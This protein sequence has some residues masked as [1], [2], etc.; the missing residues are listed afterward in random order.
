MHSVM[1]R[2]NQMSSSVLVMGALLLVAVAMS[3]QWL[4]REP[5]LR[6]AFRR[7]QV[8]ERGAGMRHRRAGSAQP[9]KQLVV[10]FDL[11]ADFT[12]AWHWNVKN[13][14]VSVV[15]SY[16]TTQLAPEGAQR[17]ASST[18]VTSN[19]ATSDDSHVVVEHHMVLWDR[20]ISSQDEAR[21]F[22][23]DLRSKY[24]PRHSD[25]SMVPLDRPMTLH[26]EY[27]IFPVV[28]AFT[29]GSSALHAFVLNAEES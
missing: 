27:M 7:A 15:A 8:V 20:V 3:S 10:E 9:Q 1:A 16:N 12:Q 13:V 5:Q 6:V 2:M 26:V 29:F 19:G 22:S 25:G 17:R 18:V 28:G 11:E 24:S 23:S 4:A 14:Y 21:I